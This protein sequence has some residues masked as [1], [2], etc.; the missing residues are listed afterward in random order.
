MVLHEKVSQRYYLV[1]EEAPPHCHVRHKGLI[2][3]IMFLSAVGCPYYYPLENGQ[4]QGYF[5]GKIGIWAVGEFVE[6]QRNSRNRARGTPVWRNETMTREKYKQMLIN[7]VLPAVH[8][9]FP[10]HAHPVVRLQQ[11]NA[12]VHCY[13]N[14]ADVLAAIQN[15][16]LNC[17]IIN[18][19]ANS[20]DLNVNDLGFFNSLQTM[21]L[22]NPSTTTMQLKEAVETAHHNYHSSKLKDVFLTLQAVMNCILEHEGGNDY[23]LPYLGRRALEQQGLLPTTLLA[24]QS[25]IDFMTHQQEEENDE[26]DNEEE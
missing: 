25:A 13:T 26:T 2:E 24:P 11:D 14:D 12:P 17:E 10:C 3:K 18:Q 8:D 19:P 9:R 21:Q 23:R 4:G 5:D 15:L 16:G 20:P 1:D 22:R 7:L 6:A